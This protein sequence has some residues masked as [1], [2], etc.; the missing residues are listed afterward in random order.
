M[1]SI[2]EVAVCKCSYRKSAR[3]YRMLTTILLATTFALYALMALRALQS[4][5]F[6]DRV[7]AAALVVGLALLVVL[8]GPVASAWLLGCALAYLVSQ[9]NTGARP[10][11]RALPVVAGLLAGVLGAAYWVLD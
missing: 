10:L 4:A 1:L 2:Y 9:V 11:S 3:S 8:P 5:S 7:L 6:W